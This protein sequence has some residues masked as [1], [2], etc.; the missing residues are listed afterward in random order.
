MQSEQRQALGGGVEMLTYRLRDAL[1]QLADGG[2]DALV[3]SGGVPTPAIADLD[4][5]LPLRILDS[6]RWRHR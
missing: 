3:W 1:A 5:E 2:I 4:T 6:V